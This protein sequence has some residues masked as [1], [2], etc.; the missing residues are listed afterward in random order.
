MAV[1]SDDIIRITAEVS[2]GETPENPDTPEEAEFRA[3]VARDIAK[4]RAKGIMIE[5]PH[6]IPR[7]AEIP[8]AG[9]SGAARAATPRGIIPISVLNLVILQ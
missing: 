7:R 2:N 3:E 6:E 9:D 1:K 5:I 8:V 4:M